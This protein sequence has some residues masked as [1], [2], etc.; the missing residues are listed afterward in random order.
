MHDFEFEGLHRY[1]NDKEQPTKIPHT[2]YMHED[3][4][5]M[6]VLFLLRHQTAAAA[7]TTTTMATALG[8]FVG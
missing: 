3:G 4:L 1:Y 8:C 7:P 6:L 5:P 2:S